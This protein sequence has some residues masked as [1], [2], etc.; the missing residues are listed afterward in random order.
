MSPALAGLFVFVL[1]V[2]VQRLQGFKGFFESR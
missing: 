2:F 1:K